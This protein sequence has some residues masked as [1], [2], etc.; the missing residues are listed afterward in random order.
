MGLQGRGQ[1]LSLRWCP[2]TWPLQSILRK[3]PWGCL[4]T[5]EAAHSHCIA[6]NK[7]FSLW[8]PQFSPLQ[9]SSDNPFLFHSPLWGPNEALRTAYFVNSRALADVQHPSSYYSPVYIKTLLSKSFEK[10][11]HGNQII[12][13]KSSVIRLS[14]K[15]ASI[16]IHCT[17]SPWRQRLCSTPTETPTSAFV[18]CQDNQ[19]T[20]ACSRV[21]AGTTGRP[22]T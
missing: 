4:T 13:A 17:H 2:S 22:T 5:P 1:P 12:K 16:R 21:S 8:G 10:T 3:P 20:S 6:W 9:N 11:Y 14:L 15:P 19:P 18:S 7:P